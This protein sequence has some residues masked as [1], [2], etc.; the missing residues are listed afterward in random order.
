[1]NMEKGSSQGPRSLR[2]RVAGRQNNVPWGNYPDKKTSKQTPHTF[3]KRVKQVAVPGQSDRG[4]VFWQAQALLGYSSEALQMWQS[5]DVDTCENM[6]WLD[7]FEDQ[8]SA[9]F[10]WRRDSWSRR[11]TGRRRELSKTRNNNNEMSDVLPDFNSPLKI[12]GGPTR[13]QGGKRNKHQKL[14]SSWVTWVEFRTLTEF[15]LNLN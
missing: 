13:R 6:C 10:C 1:M 5:I 12:P 14:N 4:T 11:A 9:S 8:E 7:E 15:Q 2:W 3:P